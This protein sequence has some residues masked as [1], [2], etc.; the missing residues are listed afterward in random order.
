MLVRLLSS[1]APTAS[2]VLPAAF[3]DAIDDSRKISAIKELRAASTLN[4]KSSKD[5][6]DAIMNKPKPEP[7]DKPEDKDDSGEPEESEPEGA[8]DPDFDQYP[9]DYDTEEGESD[10]EVDGADAGDG[11]GQEGDTADNGQD[12]S[13]A[14]A[15]AIADLARKAHDNGKNHSEDEIREALKT[16]GIQ[17]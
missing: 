13:N 6:V 9:D 16:L 17:F 8:D 7:E 3:W 2:N 10:G 5:I 1:E 15:D 14:T 4:L 11:D 12:E